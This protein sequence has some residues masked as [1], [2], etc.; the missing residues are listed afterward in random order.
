MGNCC[1][2]KD[3]KPNSEISIEQIKSQPKST[4]AVIVV[5]SVMQTY[6]SQKR[7]KEVK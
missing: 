6:L 3:V 4:A 5:Q 7:F 1:H 2:G